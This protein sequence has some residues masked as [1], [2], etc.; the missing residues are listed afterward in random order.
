M[1]DAF[2]YIMSNK[3]KTVLYIGVTNN[4]NRRVAEHKEGEGGYFTSKYNLTELIFRTI[5]W[6]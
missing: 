6:D 5:S 4:I 1:K 2:V 3:N